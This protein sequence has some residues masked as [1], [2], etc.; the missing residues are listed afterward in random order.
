MD[1]TSH[2]PVPKLK[3]SELVI[4]ASQNG[5]D[6]WRPVEPEQVP[7]WLK[8][9]PVVVGRLVAGGTVM[10]AD[11]GANGSDWYAGMS[12]HDA[13]VFLEAQDKRLRRQAK[14][15]AEMN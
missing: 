2:D 7:A 11:E 3:Q 10:K 13:A 4:L 15:L 8:D 12:P 1:H 6:G 14:Q 9:D 5:R